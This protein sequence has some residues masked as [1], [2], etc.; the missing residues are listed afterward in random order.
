MIYK[1]EIL[2]MINKDNTIGEILEM[3]FIDKDGKETPIRNESKG[4]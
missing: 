3:N 1:G 4:S 2:I